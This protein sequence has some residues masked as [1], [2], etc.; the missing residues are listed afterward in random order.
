MAGESQCPHGFFY[1]E[2]W[3]EAC[4]IQAM[5][6]QRLDIKKGQ[7]VAGQFKGKEIQPYS[8]KRHCVKCGSDAKHVIRYREDLDALEVVCRICNYYWYCVPKDRV[9]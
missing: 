8:D 1:P 3:C 9:A 2:K 4:F 5:G 7:H 6:K